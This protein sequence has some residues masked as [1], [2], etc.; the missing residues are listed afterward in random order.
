VV[1]QRAHARALFQTIR[2]QPGAR[3]L[4]ACMHG[5]HRTRVLAEIRA[6]LKNQRPC[7]VI[8]TSLIE[9]G[10]DVDFPLVLRASAGLD[11]IA[12]TLA[13]ASMVGTICGLYRTSAS[14]PPEP[15]NEGFA[16][17]FA[18]RLMTAPGCGTPVRRGRTYVLPYTPFAFACLAITAMPPMNVPQMPRM[19]MC[20]TGRIEARKRA[21]R[22]LTAA[23]SC[24]RCE[25]LGA[26]PGVRARAR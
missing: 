21:K 16:E 24:P 7:R 23:G 15:L 8:S 2:D 5:V 22:D 3:H 19:C 11:Q 14:G 10:V 9:A 26:E 6:D 25:S 17:T 4:S 20:I 18:R 1:N 12:P 13:T